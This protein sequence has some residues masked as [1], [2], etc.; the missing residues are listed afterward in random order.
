[1]NAKIK[2]SNLPDPKTWKCPESGL[3]HVLL[4]A[5]KI[6]Y[7]AMVKEYPNENYPEPEL[8]FVKS[9]LRHAEKELG[10]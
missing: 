2:F 6:A 7:K 4:A 3:A 10:A 8:Q 5:L 9:V 1:M